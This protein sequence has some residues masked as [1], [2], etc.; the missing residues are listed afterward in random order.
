MIRRYDDEKKG[1]KRDFMV[2]IFINNI[3]SR[4]KISSF[5]VLIVIEIRSRSHL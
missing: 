1:K 5:F 2:A 3:H 4:M